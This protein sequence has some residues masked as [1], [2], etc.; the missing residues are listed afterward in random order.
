MIDVRQ[1]DITLI[2]LA[3]FILWN[4]LADKCYL[5]RALLKTYLDYCWN[6]WEDIIE[7]LEE[8]VL[9]I[10][11]NILQIRNSQEDAK[12]CRDLRNAA[13]NHLID[14]EIY[15]GNESQVDNIKEDRDEGDKEDIDV[16]IMDLFSHAVAMIYMYWKE[17]KIIDCLGSLILFYL[18]HFL[19]ITDDEGVLTTRNNYYN[20]N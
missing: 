1:N 9:Y 17:Q 3:L 16:S 18:Y 11:K 13:R 12:L 5:H 15:D 8:Y 4:Q 6:I 19:Q 14:I 20:L 7:K 2:L 10:T